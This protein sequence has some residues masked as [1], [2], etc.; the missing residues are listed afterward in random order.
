MTGSATISIDQHRILIRTPHALQ[1]RDR[2][3]FLTRMFACPHLDGIDMD[4]AGRKVCLYIAGDQAS[5]KTSVLESLTALLD[6]KAASDSALAVM[7][8]EQS[9]RFRRWRGVM[10][11]LE[12]TDKAP[13]L[14]DI[15]IRGAHQPWMNDSF[16]SARMAGLP[17]LNEIGYRRFPRRLMVAFD[18][19]VHPGV[20]V[21]QLETLLGGLSQGSL[22]DVKEP[23]SLPF[24]TSNTNLA[25]S[26]TSQFFFPQAIPVAC[27]VLLV[28]RVPHIKTTLKELSRGKV[29]SPFFGTVVLACSVAT[30]SPFASALAEW[31]TRV[32]ERRLRRQLTRESHLLLV[33]LEPRNVGCV[34]W[35][36]GAEKGVQRGDSIPFDGVILHGDLLVQ[37]VLG[38]PLVTPVIRKRAG[39]SVETGYR[40]LGGE[41]QLVST[42]AGGLSRLGSVLQ[43]VGAFP[44][45]L[46]DDPALRKESRRVA[47]KAVL[48]N[49]AISGLAV[50]TGGLPMASAVLHQDWSVTPTVGAP[51]EFLR[52]VRMALTRGALIRSPLAMP[53]LA[54]LRIL[55]IDGEYPGLGDVRFR[56]SGVEAETDGLAFAT[57]WAPALAEWVG[58]ARASAFRDYAG[59]HAVPRREARFINFAEGVLELEIEGYR[60]SL[61]DVEGTGGVP[62]LRLSPEGEA[63]EVIRFAPG[64]VPRYRTVLTELKGLGIAP[65]LMGDPQ[66]AA[67]SALASQLG[68]EVLSS[69]LGEGQFEAVV[70]NLK[71][72]G[73]PVGLLTAQTL[74][75]SWAT[76]LD[77]ILSPHDAPI[78]SACVSVSLLGPSLSG[79]PDLIRAARSLPNRVAHASLKTAPTNLLCILGAF[80]GALNGAT[81]TMLAH[82][83]VF[84]ATTHQSLQAGKR[85]TARQTS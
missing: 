34:E 19:L 30:L 31:L 15:R 36:A 77:A 67:L 23:S 13:G 61:Q 74:Q 24:L 21:R 84:G 9:R 69:R 48:P 49:L 55:L 75:P 18:P 62:D 28:T 60:V 59:L 79:L 8:L 52:D 57:R 45:T 70:A 64:D 54:R 72:E 51:V 29:G 37:D 46:P 80:T 63:P 33:D 68:A 26:T 17:G 73:Y 20:W 66:D 81:A 7:P 38:D 53:G 56:V 2:R 78:D 4:R 25:L 14:V 65:V 47:D 43:T 32:W 35:V 5:S 3:E 83:G 76:H 41:G 58:D 50:A 11:S 85:K 12:L 10:T 44:Q 42:Q 40:I 39:D 16:L 82:A 27:A 1:G 6:G 22:S 71:Q